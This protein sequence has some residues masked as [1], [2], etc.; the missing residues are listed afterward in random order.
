MYYSIVFIYTH[1]CVFILIFI[2][3][4]VVVCELEACDIKTNSLNV[5]TYLSIKLFLILILIYI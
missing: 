5:Q 3:C 4:V 1:M 2:V